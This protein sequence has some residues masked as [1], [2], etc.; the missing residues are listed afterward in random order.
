ML[1]LIIDVSALHTA[2]PYYTLLWV[3]ADM[4]QYRTCRASVDRFL[5]DLIY[6]AN[7]TWEAYIAYMVFFYSCFKRLS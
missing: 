2:G 3:A 5:F 1:Q 4:T 6:S 7:H